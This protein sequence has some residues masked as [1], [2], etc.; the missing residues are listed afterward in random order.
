MN[1][2]VLLSLSTCVL[3]CLEVKG[4]YNSN[5]KPMIIIIMMLRWSLLMTYITAITQLTSPGGNLCL[6]DTLTYTCVTYE[7]GQLAWKINGISAGVFNSQSDDA[8]TSLTLITG[9]T[10]TLTAEDES[11]PALSSDLIISSAG[12]DVNVGDVISCGDGDSS[13]ETSTLS[14]IRKS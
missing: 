2:W 11:R 10:V 6:G 12:V 8:G 13:T 7:T 14:L 1:F 9:V 3:F 4:S 5:L